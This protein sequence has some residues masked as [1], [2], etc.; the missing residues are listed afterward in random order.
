MIQQKSNVS[1]VQFTHAGLERVIL[2]Q[3]NL[4]CLEEK[5]SFKLPLQDFFLLCHTVVVKLSLN[6]SRYFYSLCYV[7]TNWNFLQN[8]NITNINCKCKLHVPLHTLRETACTKYNA[9]QVWMKSAICNCKERLKKEK[10]RK[11]REAG[12]NCL[13]PNDLTHT[14]C[15]GSQNWKIL[16]TTIIA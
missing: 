13:S 1:H 5:L 16:S 9:I 14:F 2:L 7:T 3:R 12:N 11:K 8:T 6:Q 10:R 15:V 4:H